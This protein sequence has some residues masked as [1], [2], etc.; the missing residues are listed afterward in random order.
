MSSLN[1]LELKHLETE[2]TVDGYQL[3]KYSNPR[4]QNYTL[5]LREERFGPVQAETTLSQE[6]DADQLLQA[7]KNTPI[8]EVLEE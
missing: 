6:K 5:L 3:E 8:K 7:S 2:T 4:R 1:Y